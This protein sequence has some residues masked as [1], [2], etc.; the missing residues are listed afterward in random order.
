MDY[1]TP[2]GC[3]FHEA[4]SN[5]CKVLN[6]CIEMNLSLSLEKRDFLMNEGT[7]LGHS[8]SKEGIQVEPNKISIIKRV[9]TPKK[10]RDSRN[11]LGLDGYYRRFIKDFIKVASPLFGLLVKD[12]EFYWKNS[13]QEA[14]EILK[15]KL[16]TAPILRG[17]NWAFPFHIHTNAL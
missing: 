3:D 10:Q 16:T 1:F 7:V 2:Y 8:I 11:L 14:V 12:L 13:C 17:P 5:L 9:P 15:E 4:L 6:K